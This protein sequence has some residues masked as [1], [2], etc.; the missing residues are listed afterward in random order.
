MALMIGIYHSVGVPKRFTK[1]KFK[2][3]LDKL[4]VLRLKVRTLSFYI[5]IKKR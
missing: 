1:K 2:H 4:K 3:G 5:T